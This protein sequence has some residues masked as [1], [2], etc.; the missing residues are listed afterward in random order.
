MPTTRSRDHKSS[1]PSGHDSVTGAVLT[2]TRIS[3]KEPRHCTTTSEHTPSIHLSTPP[4]PIP[5]SC[6]YHNHRPRSGNISCCSSAPATDTR[7]SSRPRCEASKKRWT[8]KLRGLASPRPIGLRPGHSTIY[9]LAA[10]A[11]APV[12]KEQHWLESQGLLGVI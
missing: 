1:R 9:S 3:V 12:N 7:E 5:V 4:A 6:R 11:P 8:E 2:S 10:L